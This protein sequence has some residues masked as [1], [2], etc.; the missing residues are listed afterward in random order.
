MRKTSLK[1]L[2]K[3]HRGEGS[4][5]KEGWIPIP[6]SVGPFFMLRKAMQELETQEHWDFWSLVS[7]L[8]RRIHVNGP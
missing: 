3:Q 5:K 8:R 1:M 4:Q 2:P 7:D 6:L